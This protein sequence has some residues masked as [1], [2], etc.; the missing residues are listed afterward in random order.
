MPTSTT[1]A[2]VAESASHHAK[3]KG[4]DRKRQMIAAGVLVVVG[5]AAA[6]LWTRPA[7]EQAPLDPK[8]EKQADDIAKNLRAVDHQAEEQAAIIK[9][10]EESPPPPMPGVTPPKSLRGGKP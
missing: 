4:P 8:I 6:Y 7:V 1:R 10:R 9:A 2:S 5:S 3:P